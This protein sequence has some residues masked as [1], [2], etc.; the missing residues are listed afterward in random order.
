MLHG[1]RQLERA[2]NQNGHTYRAAERGAAVW[3]VPGVAQGS[4]VAEGLSLQL[5]AFLPGHRMCRVSGTGAECGGGNCA[6]G[7]RGVSESRIFRLKGCARDAVVGAKNAAVDGGVVV[8]SREAEEVSWLYALE[9]RL[10]RDSVH[11]DADTGV[12]QP[13]A[14]RVAIP[15]FPRDRRDMDYPE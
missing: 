1:R 12:A 9:G 7:R 10:L 4:G 6:A 2:Y 5:A 8:D 14:F 15:G 11:R 3:A 13:P